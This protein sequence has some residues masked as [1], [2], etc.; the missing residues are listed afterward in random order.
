[1]YMIIATQIMAAPTAL[2]NA[3][4]LRVMGGGGGQGGTTAVL[5]TVL[6]CSYIITISNA[7]FAVIPNRNGVCEHSPTT[8]DID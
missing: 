7:L 4:L 5:C 3:R 8:Q 6:C 2:E 1:M